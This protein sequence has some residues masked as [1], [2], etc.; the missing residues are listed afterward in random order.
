MSRVI[1]AQH[2]SVLLLGVAFGAVLVGIVS[3]RLRNRRGVM[4][5]YAVLYARPGCP[6]SCTRSGRC[7]RHS[8]GSG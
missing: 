5:V 8:R 1:A 2:T 4:R 3:D 6:G 7:R